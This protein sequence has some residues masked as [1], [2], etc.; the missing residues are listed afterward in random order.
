MAIVSLTMDVFDE[1]SILAEI[2]KTKFL[3]EFR[4]YKHPH[5]PLRHKNS[6]V[7]YIWGQN[8]ICALQEMT[9]K[10]YNIDRISSNSILQFEI[11]FYNP[12]WIHF[13]TVHS[14]L[15]NSAIYLHWIYV[16]LLLLLSSFFDD[17]LR[18]YQ[19]VSEQSI[20]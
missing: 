15:A 2:Y 20:I 4:F 3:E 13:F 8:N 12:Y 7:K 19:L 18:K 1:F 10:L 17:S 14:A 16:S 5:L 6:E 11:I 9:L